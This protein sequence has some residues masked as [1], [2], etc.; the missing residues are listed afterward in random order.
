VSDAAADITSYQLP[1][2]NES[3]NF[4]EHCP[5]SSFGIILAPAELLIAVENCHL[6]HIIALVVILAPLHN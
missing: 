1:Q 4:K 2:H 6:L 3:L 5:L